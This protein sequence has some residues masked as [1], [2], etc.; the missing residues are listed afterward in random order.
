LRS[1]GG[2]SS[3]KGNTNSSGKQPGSST[4]AFPSV[5]AAQQQ[6]QPK[7]NPKKDKALRRQRKQEKQARKQSK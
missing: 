7:G 3:N 5:H 4:F 6:P 1:G 2:S